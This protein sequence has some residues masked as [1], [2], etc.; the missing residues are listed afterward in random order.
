MTPW[1]R[2]FYTETGRRIRAARK[3]KG[4]RQSALAEAVGLTR[5][6]IVNIEAGKQKMLMHTLLGIESTLGAEHLSLVPRGGRMER[7]I[8]HVQSRNFKPTHGSASEERK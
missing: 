6:S 7:D 5:T 3:A 1:E 4:M 2:E 8:L